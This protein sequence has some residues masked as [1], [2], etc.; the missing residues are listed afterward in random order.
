MVKYKWLH[1]HFIL[2]RFFFCGYIVLSLIVV[3]K[4]GELHGL[5]TDIQFLFNL[6]EFGGI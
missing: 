1:P 6:L 3:M 5:S 4:G 2:Y